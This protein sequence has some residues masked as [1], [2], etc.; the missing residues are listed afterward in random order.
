VSITLIH[1]FQ[2]VAKRGT[3]EANVRTAMTASL[4]KSSTFSIEEGSYEDIS[5]E[6]GA[7]KRWLTGLWSFA[8]IKQLR[9]VKGH[10]ENDQ[11]RVVFRPEVSDLE[12]GVTAIQRAPS[13]GTIRGI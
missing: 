10:L 7:L 5:P 12:A 2:A 13:T 1:L 11:R 8:K 3:K 9:H 6:Q 4:K